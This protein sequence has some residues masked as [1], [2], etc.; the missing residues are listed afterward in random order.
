VNRSE[1]AAARHSFRSA[2]Q[3]WKPGDKLPSPTW[4]PLLVSENIH[5]ACFSCQEL[6]E[7]KYG[8]AECAVC[9]LADFLSRLTLEA[10]RLF[11]QS[12]KEQP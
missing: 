7:I 6:L 2:Q 11:I 5:A 1:R 12:K 3:N 4:L 10:N 9:P 8:S